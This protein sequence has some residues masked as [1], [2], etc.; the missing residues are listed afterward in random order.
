MINATGWDVEVHRYLASPHGALPA[1]RYS[2]PWAVA[3]VSAT[4]RELFQYFE[5][6][7]AVKL[8]S[9]SNQPLG[10][11]LLRL[12]SLDSSAASVALQRALMAS[13]SQYRYGPGLRAEELKLSAIH[14]L[15]ASA[16]GGIQSQSAVQHV[17]A[18]MV[19]CMLETQKS[20]ASS[21]QWL[22]YL[23]SAWRVIESVSLK[24][25]GR[26][27][28]GPIMLEWAYYHE[29]MARFSLRHWRKPDVVDVMQRRRPLCPSKLTSWLPGDRDW[30]YTATGIIQWQRPM[31]HQRMFEPLHLLS[32]VVAE[33]L[34]STHPTA[35]TEEYKGTIA[36]LKKRARDLQVPTPLDPRTQLAAARSEVFRA[37]TL[38]YLSRATTDSGLA[39]P[40][41]LC[42]LVD[43]SL[44][45]MQHMSPCE[46][47]LPLLILG[48]EA[49]TDVERLRVLDLVSSTT[50]ERELHYIRML[51]HALWTQDDLHAEE[52]VEPDYMEKLSV[53]FS[54]SSMLPH[55]G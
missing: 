23:Y 20:P 15:S 38:V 39:R 18:G 36:Q 2:L 14:A 54:A 25:F 6:K 32:E 24:S 8:S 37:S 9:F 16:A 4:E 7:M 30:W 11:T 40:L 29:V 49:R 12:A 21:S 45:L 43:K 5:K 17:A 47:P 44:A 35:H 51:L 42:L 33:V 55:F 34:P 53:V 22:C 31:E 3:G 19:I 1:L 46:R 41:E 27:A 28:E 10:Q 13:A 48:C 50:P 26:V 52:N